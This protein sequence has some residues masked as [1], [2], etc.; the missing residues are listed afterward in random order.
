MFQLMIA[1]VLEEV[2][3]I[4]GDMSAGND[5]LVSEAMMACKSGRDGDVGDGNYKE[6]VS[7]RSE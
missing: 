4:G 3:A 1:A 6:E 2:E 7:T 5:M